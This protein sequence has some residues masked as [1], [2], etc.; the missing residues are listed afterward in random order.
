ML[1]EESFN[2]IEIFLV[3]FQKLWLHRDHH[4]LAPSIV[5]DLPNLSISH[6]KLEF[7]TICGGRHKV[8]LNT[9]EK[10][11][12]ALKAFDISLV[13]F[14]PLTIQKDKIEEWLSQRN[15]EFNSYSTL[16][17]FIN[18]GKGIDAITA[19]NKLLNST[20]YGMEMIAKKYGE[21][22]YSVKYEC[23]LEIAHYAKNNDII[24]IISN[25][26][27]FILFDGS[28]RFWSS[29]DIRITPSN[30]LKTVEYEQK[31][32]N[33][34]Q[35][36]KFQLPLFATLLGNDFTL[37]YY[38][39]LLE[40][41][42]S[43]GPLAYKIHGVARYVRRVGR[44]ELSDNDIR[45]IAQKAFGNNSIDKQQLLRKSLK[46]YSV[47]VPPTI[48]DDPIEKCLINTNM[49]RSY[50]A[51]IS[52]IQGI[53]LPFYDMRDCKQGGNLSLLLIDWLKRKIGVLKQKNQNKSTTF[54]L[55]AMKDAEEDFEAHY[56]QPIYPDCKFI[57]E[58]F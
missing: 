24:A 42:N 15:Q 25:N 21:V 6:S 14:S 30:E 33:I 9:F 51:A 32:E 10:F 11:L 43:L 53:L 8:T 23:N 49:Y 22:F 17:Y 35:L 55:L 40:F 18:E 56:E 39:E 36:D 29:D 4:G 38:E 12:N 45:E 44:A 48:I 52:P 26:M 19:D 27:D 5:I 58:F 28:W 20:I 37:K 3:S 13:F 16:Y 57:V 34:C 54:T 41:H 50:M 47:D 46:S 7:D 1:H 2:S 31:I